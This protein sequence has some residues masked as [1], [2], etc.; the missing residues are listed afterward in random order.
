MAN[1][2]FGIFCNLPLVIPMSIAFKRYHQD[3]HRYLADEILDTDVPT[4]LE[5]KLFCTTFGKLCWVFLQPLLYTVR[6]LIM[7]PKAPTKLEIFNIIVQMA[8]NATVAQCFGWKMVVYLGGGFLM[9]AGLHP[10]AGHFISEHYMFAKGFETY[11]YYGPLNA[12]TWN[13]GYH[14]KHHDFPSIPGSKLPLVR[15]IASE[16]YDNLPHHDSWVKVLYDFITDPAIGPY[17]RIKRKSC[18][19]T[20]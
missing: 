10:I 1:R 6:P 8:F 11:S 5:A 4:L 9:V 14:N 17:A 7:S 18:G 19:L 13:V 3:H 2:L 12:I 20:S 16:F 15:K